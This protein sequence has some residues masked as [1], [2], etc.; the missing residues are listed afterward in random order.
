MEDPIQTIISLAHTTLGLK[1]EE[2]DT[3]TNIL[4]LGLDSL[5]IIKLAQEI[6]RRFGVA[7]E[8]R[9]FLTTMPSLTDLANH[10]MELRSNDAVPMAKAEKA[11]P[12]TSAKQAPLPA[13]DPPPKAISSPASTNLHPLF[14]A[15]LQSMQELFAQ[16][17]NAL[18]PSSSPSSPPTAEP[19]S[20]SSPAPQKQVRLKR[21][22]RGF[23]FEPAPLSEQQAAFV[24]GLVQRHA[25]RTQKSRSL[26]RHSAVLAD[27]KSS[28]SFRPELHDIAYP[29][30][31]DSTWGGRFRD[32]DGNEYIDIAV[33][34]GVHF[35]GHN[36]PYVVEAL[37]NRLGRGFGLG[38]QCD[39]TSKAAERISRLTGME[40]VSFCNTG[41]EAV[42]FAIRL[43]R[44][45]TERPLIALF[46][47]SYHG[48]F[49]GILAASENGGT[50]T[51]SPGTPLAMVQDVLVLDYNSDTAFTLLEER[52]QDVAAVLVEP[53]QSRKPNLQPQTFLRRLR[54]FTREKG[55]CLIFD[56]VV[57]GFRCA[58]G[59]AQEHF[60]IRA[61]LALYGKVVGGGLH[62]G[63]V[64]GSKEY[65]DYID[66]G[67]LGKDNHPAKNKT[68]VFGGTFCRHPLSMEGVCAATGYLL[69][70]GPS[71]QKRVS[72]QTNLLADRLN[73]WFQNN[74][75]P[76]RMRN[77]G[78]QFIFEGFGPYS[79]LANPIELT[80]FYL[81]LMERGIY[82]WERRTC[83]LS[84]EHTDEDIR[85]IETAV[86]ESVQALRHGGF[87]FKLDHGTPDI[88][89]PMSPTEE[90][91]YAI[92]QR[93]HGQDA[94][95]LPLAWKIQETQQPLDVEQLEISLGQ[96]ILRHEALRS[97]FH[98]IDEHL[99]RKVVDEPAFAL[100]RIHAGERT[101]E[102]I[103]SDFIRPFDLERAPLMRAGLATL[104]DGSHV[105]MLDLLHIVADGTSLGI[106][107]DDLNA[108]MNGHAPIE[109][110]VSLR[111]IPHVADQDRAA[112]DTQFWVQRLQDLSPRNIPL[113]FPSRS[114]SPVGR[115]E[116]ITL[117]AELTAQAYRAC[118]T[119]S[120]TMNMFL[121]AIYTLFLHKITDG[122]RFCVGMADGG[123]H[124][125]I[126]D[127]VVG[128]FV[129]TVPQDF[130]IQPEW[131]LPHFMQQIRLACAESM[132]RNRAPY[133]EIVKGLDRSPA[134]TM[135]SYEKADQRR[136]TW[137][138]L[139]FT[140][141]VPPGRGAMYD[142]A[143]DIV[144]MDGVLHCNL[145][146]S[147]ALRPETARCFGQCFAHLVKEVARLATDPSVTL[148]SVSALPPVQAQKVLHDWQGK[149]VPFDLSHTIVHLCN[150]AAQRYADRTALVFRDHH[151][152]YAELD[153]SSTMLA[154]HLVSLGAGPEQMVAI[155]LDRC[156]EFVI[157]MM[158]VMKAGA[159]FV[160][161]APDA[162][163]Q[164][165]RFQLDDT[166]PCALIST[167]DLRPTEE[168]FSGPWIDAATL[169][170]LPPQDS[171]PEPPA[172]GPKDLAYVI[173]TSGSTGQPKGVM[174]EHG[175]LTNLC[176]WFTR[177]YAIT[178]NDRTTA[179]APFIFDA[180]IWEFL[181]M[182]MQGAT[183]HILDDQTRH[184][185]PRMEDYLRRERITVAYFLSQVAEMIDGA[186]LPD[187][188]LML[189]GGETL[190]M[191][192]P[193]G[194]YR[195]CNSYG[196][197]ECTV[198]TTSFDLD[199][200]WPV[201]IGQLVDNT[202]ALILDIDGNPRPVGVPGE[203]HLAGVQVAR[204][205]LNRPDLTASAFLPNPLAPQD[206]PYARMYR[207]GDICRWLPDGNIQFLRR[208]DSQLKIRGHRIEP[209]E[210]EKA[211]LDCP[212]VRQAAVIACEEHGVHHLHGYVVTNDATLS[213][214][215]L[216]TMLAQRLPAYMVPDRLM[217]LEKMPVNASGKVDKQSL[218]AIP[219]NADRPF[220]P[221]RTREERLLAEIWSEQLHV[222]QVG[223]EDSFIDLGGDSIKA[224]M[225][226][227]RIRAKGYSLDASDLLR[228]TTIASL[229]PRMTAVNTQ[230]GAGTE[231]PDPKVP[232]S[233][234]TYLESLFGERMQRVYNLAPL[235]Q[236]M[237]FHARLHPHSHAYMEQNLLLLRGELRPDQLHQRIKSLLSRHDIFRTAFV[238]HGVSRPWQV[239]LGTVDMDTILTREDMS[240]LS[241]KD[242][243][244]H[245][246]SLMR[247]ERA[248]G[249]DLEHPP[250]IRFTL[251]RISDQEHLL[252]FT[253]HHIILDGWSVGI[254][255]NELFPQTPP[256]EHPLQFN[257][258]ID[259]L[260]AQDQKTSLH[261]WKTHLQGA[262]PSQ[263]PGYHASTGDVQ[264]RRQALELD[265][266]LQSRLH[267]LCARSNVTL[268][269][270]LQ[271][272]W[273]LLLSISLRRK[274]VVFGEVVS[275][276]SPELDGVENLIGLCSNT[277]P[278][279][280]HCDPAL[281]FLDLAHQ[282]QDTAIEA[283]RHAYCALADILSASGLHQ[284]LLTHFF[285]LENH[286]RPHVAQGI[287]GE[288]IEEFSQT[289]FDFA[290]VWEPQD[291]L[292][293][294]LVYNGA[295]FDEWRIRSLAHAYVTVLENISR[296]PDMLLGD[297]CL[298][299]PSMQDMILNHFRA[300][301]VSYPPVTVVEL[302][303]QKAA[304]QP[305]ATALV[306]GHKHLT[307]KELDQHSDA[308]AT[309]LRDAG[310]GPE[311]VVAV[312]LHR[313]LAFPVSL[314]AVLK[315]GGAFLPLAVDAPRQR[316]QFQLED[317][318]AVALISETELISSLDTQ[319]PCF[320]VNKAQLFTS[321][322]APLP[323][324]RITD[325]AYVIYTS[326]TTGLPKG[327]AVEHRSLT[328]QTLWTARH[329]A[330]NPDSRLTHFAAHAFDVSIWEIFPGLTAGATLYILDED[331]RHDLRALTRY[332]R[333]NGIT[334]TWMPPH[335][336]TLFLKEGSAVD[337]LKTL[338]AG[339]DVFTPRDNPPFSL[340][341]NYGPTECTITSTSCRDAGQ[342]NPR[343]IGK[344]V[345]NTDMFI[346]DEHDHLLPVGIPG[347]L[348]ITGIQVARGYL[349]RPDLTETVFVPNP[350]ATGPDTQRMYRTGDLCCWQ[351][352]GSIEFLG[353][354][355]AQL[356]IRGHRIEPG[357]IESTLQ[358]HPLV[359]QCVLRVHQGQLC[360]YV[361]PKNKAELDQET[362]ASFAREQ[363]PPYMV[364]E[365]V[366]FLDSLPLTVSGKINTKALPAPEMLQAVF[367]APENEA[368]KNLCDVLAEVLDLERVGLDDDFFQLGGDS[369]K[370]LMVA[371]RLW[372][373]GYHLEL[374][375]LYART[376]LATVAKSMHPAAADKADLNTTWH[377]P[378]VQ[379]ATREHL[380]KRVP[381]ITTI[382]RLTPM[383]TAMLAAA[384]RDPGA[385][386]IDNW[387][388]IQGK[389]DP[390]A[391]QNRWQEITR[392]H[393]AL[394]TI[395]VHDEHQPWQVVLDNKASFFRY[396][397]LRNLPQS[398]QEAAIRKAQ[399][400]MPVPRLD[401]DPLV[402]ILLFRLESQ[403]FRMLLSWHHIVMDGW[404]LGQVLGELFAPETPEKPPVSFL[405]HIRELTRQDPLEN[406]KW[407]QETLRELSSPALLPRRSVDNQLQ[408]TETGP[409]QLPFQLT[410]QVEQGLRSL[411]SKHGLTLNT[412]LQAAWAI[413]LARHADQ[414]DVLFGNVISGRPATI[415][416]V[417][418]LVG[419]CVQTVPV[420]AV[421]T[422]QQPFIDFA[423]S[424]Q[425]WN[426]QAEAHAHCPMA[427]LNELTGEAMHQLF[428]LENQP[429]VRT[430]DALTI[431]PLHSSGYT[432]VEFAVEWTDADRLS[433]TFHYDTASFET[434]RV[435]ALREHYL[436]LLEGAVQTPD[437]AI[438]TLPMLTAAEKRR[439]LV[440]CNRTDRTF[441]TDSTV[442]DLFR[443]VARQNPGKTALV[444]AEGTCSYGELDAR[445]DALAARLAAQGVTTETM[446]GIL[447]PR[448]EDFVIAA[449]GIM[450]A[451]AAYL[452]L[453]PSW[454]AERLEFIAQDAGLSILVDTQATRHLLT[455]AS[456][457]RVDLANLQEHASPVPSAPRPQHLAYVI[458]TSGS[459]G[460]PKG[461]LLEHAGLVNLCRWQH[462]DFPLTATDVCTTYAPWTFDASVYEIFPALTAG[463]TLHIIPE[464]L[465]LDIEALRDYFHAHGISV[466]FLPPQVGHQVLDGHEFPDLRVVTLAGDK[467][468]PLTPR[469]YQL[470]NCYGP[471]E[472]TVCATSWPVTTSR[473][474][475]PI[476]TPIANTRCH[477]LGRHG[478]LQPFGAPGELHLSG[479]QIARGYLNR[480][481]Q[482]ARA[483]VA[484]PFAQEGPHARMYRTG[485]ICRLMPDGNLDFIGRMDGQVKLRGQRLELG[486]IESALLAH[487]SVDNAVA[488]LHEDGEK[489]LLTA[490]VTP[491][492]EDTEFLLDWLTTRLPRWMV[493]GRI[494]SLQHLPLTANGKID[495]AALPAPQEEA[496]PAPSQPRTEQEKTVAAIWREVLDVASPGREDNFFALG[497]D[498]IKAMMVVSRLRARGY[499]LTSQLL[500]NH[501]RLC[502]VAA[503]LQK[504]RT[505]EPP[506]PVSPT[507]QP[508]E[509]DLHILGQRFGKRLLAVHP[510]TPM[511]EGLLYHH[512][513]EP[514]SATYIEQSNLDLR[515]PL[516]IEALRTRLAGCVQRHAMLRTLF[517]WKGLSS[518]WLI[519]VSDA[520]V[521][522][523]EEDLQDL[524]EDK[525]LERM[526]ELQ[527][528]VREH[529]L[530]LE[531]G[532]LFRL[533]LC[534]LGP[535]HH[536]LLVSF[537]H[538]ILDGWSMG[539]LASELFSAEPPAPTAPFSTY[540]HWLAS[541][542]H[543]AAQA[544]W[545]QWLQGAESTDLPGHRIKAQG[546]YD[547]QTIPLHCGSDLSR[548]LTALAGDC[549]VTINTVL[550]TAWAL[551]LSRA[552]NNDDVVFGTVLS[553]RNIDL[554]H[555]EN[556]VGLFVNTVPMRITFP[557][558]QPL[559]QVLTRVQA[560]MLRMEPHAHIPLAHI[561]QLTPLGNG[562]INHLFVFENLPSSHPDQALG[563]TTS[564]GFNQT[565]YDLALVFEQGQELN[566][567]LQFNATALD[568]WL[569]QD[570]GNHFLHVLHQMADNPD[571]IPSA[572]SLCV[573]A[574][575]SPMAVSSKDTTVVDLFRSSVA[576]HGQNIAVVCGDN[577]LTYEE[578]DTRSDALAHKLRE[579][580]AGP[581]RTIAILLPR[582][583]EYMV[584]LLA[585]LK[586]GSAY[587]TLDPAYP[588]DRMTHIL[589]DAAPCVL[590]SDPSMAELATAFDGP[591]LDVRTSYTPTSKS[592]PAPHPES[593][594]YVVYTSGT[595][596]QPKGVMI[597]HRSLAN[598]CTWH[599]Q[600]YEVTPEDRA[601]LVFSFAF[602]AAAWGIFPILAAGA[603]IDVLDDP[604]R[605]SLQRMHTHFDTHGITLAN[606]PTVLAEQFQTLAPPR[607]LRLLATGGDALRTF[608]PQPYKL[609]NEYGP[610][611]ATI[612]ATHHLVQEE[613]KPIPIGRFV[614]GTQCLILDRH[615]HL[616]P[617]GLPGELHLSGKALARGYRNQPDQT[618][619]A[620]VP[621]PFARDKEGEYAR[622]YRT[623]DLCR[624][625]P[626]GTME[627][628]GRIDN[629]LS[630]RGFR[631]EPAEIEQILLA[632]PEIRSAAVLA[633]PDANGDV[634]LCAYVVA[635]KWDETA[636]RAL[637]RRKLPAYMIPAL[638]IRMEALPLNTNGKIDQAALPELV[639]PQHTEGEPPSTALELA[640][641]RIWLDVLGMD[642]VFLDDDFFEMGGD[643]LKAMRLIAHVETN[644]NCSI[645][646]SELMNGVTIRTLARRIRDLQEGEEEKQP[647]LIPVREGS[648][649]P[650]V[651]VHTTGGSV[652]CY[653]HLIN[654]LPKERP[655][656]VLPPFGI[657]HGQ[658]PD[659]QLEKVAARYVPS[660]IQRFPRGDFLLVG[661]CM[662]GMTA[663]EIARQLL[664]ADCPV[665]GVISLN[666]RDH[667]LDD[668]LGNPVPR[669]QIPQEV[670]EQ[671]IAVGLEALTGYEDGAPSVPSMKR[672]HAFLQAQLLAWAHYEP[673]PL[674]I[675]MTCIRPKDPVNGSYQS[676][677]TRPLGWENLALGGMEERYCPGNHFSML[678]DPH[679]RSLAAIIEEIAAAP[680]PSI[681]NVPLTPIQRWL[682]SLDMNHAQFFQSV[683]LR[684]DRC[685]PATVYKKALA[686][687]SRRHDML[688]AV[689]PLE[690][691]QRQQHILT[692]GHNRFGLRTCTADE[693]QQVAA[694]IA[695]N[696]DLARG[697]LAW[698]VLVPGRKDKEPDRLALIIHHLV[699]DGV[700]WHL[701]LGDLAAALHCV[702]HDLPV[703]LP[704]APLAQHGSFAQWA[705]RLIKHAQSPEV[706][707]QRDF[708]KKQL[709]SRPSGIP[710]QGTVETRRSCE[711]ITRDLILDKKN[712]RLLLG[713]CHKAY[714]TNINDLLLT[715]LL[716]AVKSQS[717]TRKLLVDL[718]GHG[719][720]ELF[721]NLSLGGIVG[722]FTTVHPTVLC[723][724]TDIPAT[725]RS[726]HRSLRAVPSKGLGFG[727]LRYLAEIEA[728]QDYEADVLFNY[729][730]DVSGSTSGPFTLEELGFSSDVDNDFPQQAKLAV[731]GLV[732]DHRLRL[733]VDAHPAEFSPRYLEDLLEK[734]QTYLHEIIA[735]C[736]PGRTA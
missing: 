42:M 584:A 572:L 53:V 26:G 29:I 344:P 64:A 137:P 383:Q 85:Q 501:P 710:V 110:P 464:P 627:F 712:T 354:I 458:Y 438:S 217:A 66:G 421:Y 43:A 633:R 485:D 554:P 566:G 442:V 726:V 673:Q 133:S 378:T 332:L 614:A 559:R 265:H 172:P 167:A 670:P 270:L 59:G 376:D 462:T 81:L 336:A 681:Q 373:R 406:L 415:P 203:L 361:L 69:E 463:A 736:T 187:L 328:N 9:W 574:T 347:E 579:L 136:P 674:P 161:L 642:T 706:Q 432:D 200:T 687:L 295:C 594:A 105:F 79:A 32:V 58:P 430:P 222:P 176:Q 231:Q 246:A 475:P 65:I 247:K 577:S 465:R 437:A 218:P 326:G 571:I 143:L 288:V 142:F 516:D 39:L 498:S 294:M 452:P 214:N 394:R 719:R 159:A 334:D 259:W 454:P 281:S 209:L 447:M 675:P 350:Y 641:A 68:I 562:L 671:A 303:R 124:D 339:G 348:C 426:L 255:F 502:Q 621:N 677:E 244:Q 598:F 643:S 107:L 724:A 372:S 175:S 263:L 130:R 494:C 473:T 696:L 366:I 444:C 109:K 262:Q 560:D 30:V 308:L 457:T 489:N 567:R 486:E 357:E 515:G 601:G 411:A 656:F 149:D 402:R 424:I 688:R 386:I 715:A 126:M 661:L 195:H 637:L 364:P 212:G 544:F 441:E 169:R 215:D 455:L 63:V 652:R 419:L 226:T 205:Y 448:N 380:S 131:T 377:D 292:A 636:L 526:E 631:I 618:T 483:F 127:R 207:T 622:M 733:N 388:E 440:H 466:S 34:M 156:L 545:R 174:V 474:S 431:T 529:G 384:Q 499:Q 632:R 728:L 258:F 358:T 668:D 201:P 425:D 477:I 50:G 188:R 138:G 128:M 414:D 420:R 95:H 291:R 117:D 304:S 153:R 317:S 307:Y 693:L 695:H 371:S 721:E 453:D 235:Q 731:T 523:E 280:L 181:P 341:N 429:P 585:I 315:A 537:Q 120:V 472:F 591:R 490:Y 6:E 52:W 90:R 240:S 605:T 570:L 96:C 446:V 709:A 342:A 97:S 164:R 314:L 89:T 145:L 667:L 160:P 61:D 228:G 7:L 511:Q 503:K 538:S 521:V 121:N 553:G 393:D 410:R 324:P 28:L 165:I 237:L 580:G 325:L 158:G 456:V 549:Q 70:Q 111:D 113:D 170:H 389:L 40:R 556:M 10:V 535:N 669:D 75:V 550:Q 166:N 551:V 299:S 155:R 147:E 284:D 330:L 561:Q 67:F 612:M 88:F 206:S 256:V 1:P 320:D 322:A 505:T 234:L 629:Q 568:T 197:T 519:E 449:L 351:P 704:S 680:R 20:P 533:I 23:V 625:L 286:P 335:M 495:H 260:N 210:I 623:G 285:V 682:F 590:I 408:T 689:Y 685:R 22:I 352:D 611:E 493:P 390:T 72:D 478:Q 196:P 261:W 184:D 47:G 27:W 216:Q 569:V 62:V 385:Y 251:A 24:S 658:Q 487:D 718:E 702:D 713:P 679:V 220:T 375:E 277:V 186:S 312:L 470:R 496:A 19:A 283:R 340:L 592:L 686:E 91:L 735:L 609:Y 356:K 333:H 539:I 690:K 310:A 423:S 152:S 672:L 412:L 471:T 245:M 44:A 180:S 78:P 272:A 55:I 460:Q 563:I 300:P 513:R 405:A 488:V 524:P 374:K 530:D 589:S 35:L 398:A 517:A 319:L 575:I 48:T 132:A 381:N 249:F 514:E 248:R 422:P 542:D 691:G 287:Q 650:L 139:S 683:I 31:A 98:H 547:G 701:I 573:P 635:E 87:T 588:Q 659:T 18:H 12:D 135:L 403:R 607:S 41:T 33:G 450:K 76:L 162:P 46:N 651:L 13:M 232:A 705:A 596:G 548:K 189:S 104:A 296:T 604:H 397:D 481:E 101:V 504:S 555:V 94:Y 49:D 678:K 587:V 125:E 583:A 630:I 185:L 3:E 409:A 467:P 396:Q 144:E 439:L 278:V 298:V 645:P 362:I 720:Q 346:L 311:Q 74:Q 634:V 497:G 202:R 77:F 433:C 252:L 191:A 541:Q 257:A 274:D 84:T 129:N 227:S 619:H 331:L 178:H 5:M 639:R 527:R 92:F 532:P 230:A 80:L 546:P 182:L 177:H 528:S 531:E 435:E 338:T 510:L 653:H 353:R 349:N 236:A 552:V 151:I 648:G 345:H 595:T 676:F 692:S 253:V 302:F 273:A 266:D 576:R 150:E 316:L 379:T 16:Q 700:S 8:A 297:V 54:R 279:R 558:N 663:W 707:Q 416:N 508:P 56:E 225:I 391:L 86:R 99:V 725:I 146:S 500:F 264:N 36:P 436:T 241:T 723:A 140:P 306:F 387:A 360:A 413:V 219:K 14:A 223:R 599:I 318:G 382:C 355:D 732:Q 727:V 507:P 359:E 697:P 665:R 367:K 114:G 491:R 4:E 664:E 443:A 649:C 644:L 647:F 666:T 275:C 100:E 417:E 229:A 250:L 518:P 615:G 694:D 401:R 198:T 734:M 428:V 82:T 323:A 468:G 600:A 703:E 427:Q 654:A 305:Q 434:W 522:L 83:G 71:L 606:I 38:P 221:P 626:D 343:S 224:L 684:T 476:G 2:L 115:Q 268:N 102:E 657:D 608:R 57:N 93:E 662:A 581:E 597:E 543:A 602:D 729:L 238:H 461:V 193:Q 603:T 613:N 134:A 122:T 267:A 233:D 624:R 211:L 11:P 45:K 520:G 199:G 194:N 118:R 254:L 400:D 116:W 37:R 469:S 370:A 399:A 620:F 204:G 148:R 242:R 21:N 327:V 586:S 171:L 106:L 208:A 73:L 363:L 309:R 512:T 714:D 540:I 655:V 154:K 60:D 660:L 617:D 119:Y 301:E 638:F 395:F 717:G 243:Q 51:Y 163:T 445:T 157:A 112:E 525:Q 108:L 329:Y 179:F 582:S 610:S 730:G 190:H 365:H 646:I 506:V 534:V 616:Q 123:R 269:V 392:R 368:Q 480:P 15:Q 293:G 173:Y 103:L 239:V 708:W 290:V 141:L 482:T 536:A 484:N 17:L 213:M 168:Y 321:K 418:E 271:A 313:G 565:N 628:L 699:V 557:D 593:L 698:A 479:I 722:W 716:L 640:L 492:M 282:L 192:R 509:R 183:V 407:W 369:I 276:R 404:S 337:S 711:L 459:T 451:G 25:Q 289:N 564:G 578:L